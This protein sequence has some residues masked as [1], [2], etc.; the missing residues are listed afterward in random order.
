MTAEKTWTDEDTRMHRLRRLTACLAFAAPLAATAHVCA[1]QKVEKVDGGLKVT[2]EPVWRGQFRT[3]FHADRSRTE[4]PADA[5][6]FM[7]AIGDSAV[8]TVSPEDGC[9]IAA[10]LIAGAPAL[11]LSAHSPTPNGLAHQDEE[12]RP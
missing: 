11:H 5:D 9:T 2:I 4:L 6:S 7:L 1:V 12:L 3:V 8:R 10:V